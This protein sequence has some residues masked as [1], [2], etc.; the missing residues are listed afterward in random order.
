MQPCSQPRYGLIDC[1]KP[2]SGES[3]CEMMERA[4]SS[5]TV[6]SSGL[7]VSLHMRRGGRKAGS[8]VGTLWGFAGARVC[9]TAIGMQSLWLLCLG[10]LVWGVYNAYGQ[11]SR[12]AAADASSADFKPMAISLVLAGGL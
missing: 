9:A 8:A 1:E 4:R 5:V 7:P 12:F 3:L 2:T 6:V 11:Y 10:T